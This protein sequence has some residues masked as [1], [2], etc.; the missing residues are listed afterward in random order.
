MATSLVT[1]RTAPSTCCVA[2]ALVVTF[3]C[4]SRQSGAGGP[5]REPTAA[6]DPPAATAT[7]SVVAPA[8]EGVP[9]AASATASSAP[10]E[11]L[12]QKEVSFIF[13]THPRKLEP[14]ELE[15]LEAIWLLVDRG[16]PIT[17]LTFGPTKQNAEAWLDLIGAHLVAIGVAESK[18][19]K[20]PCVDARAKIVS[21]SV[22]KSPATCAD[23]G[24]VE[25]L[26]G[27]SLD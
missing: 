13:G 18:L 12:V 27:T 5:G 19:T 26:T 16:D 7:P 11:K 9:G 3:A 25:N 1:A 15:S 22:M 17:L 20:V 6:V 23:S 10:S 2:A 4:S 14:R 24:P 21:T 8:A